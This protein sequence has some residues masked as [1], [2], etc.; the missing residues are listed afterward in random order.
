MTHPA[1]RRVFVTGALGF[2][3]RALSDRYRSL[4]SDVIGVDVT[5][6]ASCGVVAGDTCEPGAWQEAADGCDLVISTAALV[7][8]MATSQRAWEVNVLGTRRALDV[9]MCGGAQRFVA[10][11]VRSVRSSVQLPMSAEVP[12]AGLRRPCCPSC[13]RTRQDV[14]PRRDVALTENDWLVAEQRA[15]VRP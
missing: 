15:N 4:G 2:V 5:A 14:P 13:G 8:N 9:A 1:P 3:G 10:S 7:T 11:Q 12:R 6:D